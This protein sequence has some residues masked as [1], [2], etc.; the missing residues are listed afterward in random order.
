M[1]IGVVNDVALAVEAL[2][3]VLATAPEH[4]LAW[5][6]RNG[7]EA[8][9]RCAEDTP[10]LILM[11]M[12]MPVMDGVEA[13]RRI[14][15]RT[16]CAIL[17]V[18]ASVGAHSARIF[19]ALGAGALDVVSTPI[20]DTRG[21]GGG[22]ALLAKIR[23][24]RHLIGSETRRPAPPRAQTSP[25]STERELVVAIGASAGGPA[26]LATILSS[27]PRDFP[28][29]I[30]IIQHVDAQF[31]IE[32]ASWLNDQSAIPVRTAREGDHPQAGVAL[33]AG[34]NDHLIFANARTLH[35]TSDPQHCSYRPSID[36]FFESLARY[37]KGRAVGVLLTGMGRDGAKGLKA[38]RDAGAYTLVES[39]ATCVVYGMP[40][41]A[42]ALDAAMDVL[43]LPEIAPR[44]VQLCAEKG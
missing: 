10:D 30:V 3:R 13:T 26:A 4:E 31:A 23:V 8:V 5:V 38:L 43:P 15:D 19:E 44:L 27:L 21:G 33:L 17:I 9:E 7:A 35:Y 29:A 41:A 20:L 36:V 2:R 11:D 39:R 22:E 34:T 6:A 14:M 32:M 16:P 25:A 42:I 18:T 28:G 1:R 12:V 37:R 24:L 40:R